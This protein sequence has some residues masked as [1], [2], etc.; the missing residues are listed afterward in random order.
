MQQL[1]VDDIANYILDTVR[2]VAEKEPDF[3]LAIE[4]YPPL[5]DRILS[6]TATVALAVELKVL[7]GKFGMSSLA[8]AQYRQDEIFKAMNKRM[9]V[10]IAEHEALQKVTETEDV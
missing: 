6:I 4:M 10:D 3:Y 2:V 9:R 1:S 8:G 5:L 7:E